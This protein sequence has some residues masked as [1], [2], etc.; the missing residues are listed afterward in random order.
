MPPRRSP[1]RSGGDG[2]SLR[3]RRTGSCRSRC[4]S[5][6]SSASRCASLVVIPGQWRSSISACTTQFRSVSGLISSCSPTRRNVPDLVAGSHRAS[7]GILVALFRGSSGYFRGAAMPFIPPAGSEPPPVPG[8]FSQHG[9]IHGT[10]PCIR[11][12][13]AQLPAGPLGS[14]VRGVTHSGVS[15]E[16]LSFTV[17]S[18][19]CP[20]APARHTQRAGNVLPNP[21][22]PRGCCAIA[23]PSE[24]S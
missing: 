20:E 2:R 7:I 23:R 10:S 12:V 22:M 14:E 4:T 1:A 8:R 19:T 13:V 3:A 16:V 6:S 18:I 9:S 15:L 17:D 21:T 11:L 5:F 24:H